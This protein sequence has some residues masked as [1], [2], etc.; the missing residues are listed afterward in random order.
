M[1]NNNKSG[2]VVAKRIARAIM[3]IINKTI[4]FYRHLSLCGARYTLYDL[5]VLDSLYRKMYRTHFKV[6]T[7]LIQEM[8]KHNFANVLEIACGTGWN[9]L[10]FKEI[11][12]EYYGL[13]ISETALAVAMTKYPE[14]RF[15]NLGICDGKMIRDNSFDVVY[16]SS[17]LEHIGY[18]KEAIME[19]IR[20]AKKEVW[21]LFFEGLSNDLQSKINFTSFKESEIK[22][23]KKDLL[24]RKI[25]LQD[26]IHEKRKGWYWNH[27]SRKEIL[28]LL[29]G[30][31]LN[32]EILDN[33]NRKFIEKETIL[34]I[35]K[36]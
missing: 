27:Y 13:D 1:P 12:L 7:G 18:H 9:I 29:E 5:N 32:V 28:E 34:I 33:S 14:N 2:I 31:D 11:G 10:N 25:V 23:L 19:M 20:I 21:I 16:S 36:V 15:F 24:G 30:R 6:H 22:G 35:R 3:E 26:H 17:M 4:R 8:Q